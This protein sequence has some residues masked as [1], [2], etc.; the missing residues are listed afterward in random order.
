MRLPFTGIPKHLCLPETMDYVLQLFGWSLLCL[1]SGRFPEV[2]HD[3][4]AVLEAFRKRLAGQAM[5]FRALLLQIKPCQPTPPKLWGWVFIPQK[6]EVA[7]SSPPKM[8]VE[9]FLGGA[10][11][12]IF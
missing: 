7:P 12:T 4:S 2:A 5:G 3:G 8:E 10:T 1:F 9:G 6:M 11:T